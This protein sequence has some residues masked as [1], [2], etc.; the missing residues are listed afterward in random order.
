VWTK[1]KLKEQRKGMY[2]AEVAKPKEGWTA[3][4]VELTYPTGMQAPMKFTTQVKVVPDV[5]PFAE[6]LEEK[7]KP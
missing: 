1:T 2:S 4:F 5:L 7:K 6:K 3:F